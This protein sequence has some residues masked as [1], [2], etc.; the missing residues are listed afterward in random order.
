MKKL[1]GPVMY[2]PDIS[3]DAN[4]AE[5]LFARFNYYGS[6]IDE[7]SNGQIKYLNLIV[8]GFFNPSKSFDSTKYPN[9]LCTFLPKGRVK[10]FKM[11]RML[12]SANTENIT[13]LI[14]GNPWIAYFHCI[15]LNMGLSL[16]IQVSIHGN[17]F[18]HN[19]KFANFSSFLKH[20]WLKFFLR[21]AT[22]VRLVSKHQVDY[23]QRAYK[24]DANRISISPIP[25]S[26]PSHFRINKP[27]KFTIG[28]V[29]RLHEERGLDLWVEIVSSYFLANKDFRVIVIGDGPDR[30][31]FE[32]ALRINCPGI[33]LDFLGRI[34]NKDI[35]SL[36]SEITLLLSTAKEESFGI[37]LREAEMSG[38][39]VIAFANSG[40]FLNKDLFPE[41]IVLFEDLRSAF[42]ALGQ[43]HSKNQI[44]STSIQRKFRKTQEEINLNSIKTMVASWG[45]PR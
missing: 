7:I 26:I 37:S 27:P 17:Q 14:A 2:I 1:Y 36:W 43:E 18:L 4:S 20:F 3:R 9:L 28:F 39:R 34:P 5:E 29:G 44:L 21:F 31:Y 33:E 15:I 22:S 10:R 45:V 13:M 38:T 40:T 25:I 8:G 35:E 12:L 32:H 23:V 6:K 42:D 30:H 16:P 24:V 11:L 19:S 41:G